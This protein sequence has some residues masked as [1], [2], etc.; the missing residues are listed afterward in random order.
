LVL[1]A[2]AAINGSAATGAYFTHLLGRNV[3]AMHPCSYI[4]SGRRPLPR[5]G[6]ATHSA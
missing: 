5:T 4:V 3:I 1:S 6:R 2:Q